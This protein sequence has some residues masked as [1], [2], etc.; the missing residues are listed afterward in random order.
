ME[1]NAIAKKTLIIPFT[2]KQT[3]WFVWSRKFLA[4]A[5]HFGYNRIIQ[6]KET[7]PKASGVSKL[8]KE[9]SEYKR[10]TANSKGYV[11]IPLCLM[12]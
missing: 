10:F 5:H 6:G 12:N 2:G 1:T 8:K 11:R 7:V 9:S 4:R 3:D